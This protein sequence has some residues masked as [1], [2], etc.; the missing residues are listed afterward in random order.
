M[1]WETLRKAIHFAWTASIFV[2]GAMLLLSGD[3]SFRPGGT[4]LGKPLNV[5]ETPLLKLGSIRAKQ[6]YMWPRVEQLSR[7]YGLDPTL[8]MAVIQVES[9]FNHLA[10][11]RRGA[12]GLM[13][14]MPDTSEEL[15]LSN[16]LD[17]EAN[18]EA[19]VAYL[20]LLKR[21]FRGIR[22]T[23]A[24]YNAGPAKVRRVRGIPRIRETRRYVRRVLRERYKFRRRYINHT[25][26]YKRIAS[27]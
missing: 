15:G 2:A 14:L 6:D 5:S 16:P 22:R 20:A 3:S 25:R 27:R 12:A 21:S 23:L 11:S 10:I 18:L 7:S 19:G 13:Q 4:L 1:R 9:R 8:V 26:R 24:A 17:P